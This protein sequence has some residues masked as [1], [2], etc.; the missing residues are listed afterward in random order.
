MLL[1]TLPQLYGATDHICIIGADKLNA[2][3][4]LCRTDVTRCD[5]TV[6]ELCNNILEENHIEKPSAITD[7]RDLYIYLRSVI[8]NLLQA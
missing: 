4:A 8:R 5:E 1:Y 2:A 3:D 7:L 6:L